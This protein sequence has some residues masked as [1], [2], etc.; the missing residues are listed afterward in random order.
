MQ[1]KVLENGHVVLPKAIRQRLGL[2]EGD[3]LT[4]NVT[5]GNIVL[6]RQ[7]KPQK[8]RKARIV[9]SSVTGLP[10]I[11]VDKNTPVLTSEIVRD[12]LS[13]FP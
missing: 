1:A 3:Q 10:V 8:S 9:T 6:S 2:E 5:D 13:D 12:L 4:A 7:T 11:E